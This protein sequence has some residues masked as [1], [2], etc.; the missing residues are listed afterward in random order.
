MR[1]FFILL[2]TL[3]CQAATAA[4]LSVSGSMVSGGSAAG[5]DLSRGATENALFQV[6]EERQGALVGNAGVV[7]D[8]LVGVN[9]GIG[10]AVLGTDGS[11]NLVLPA[12]R[13]DSHIIHFDPVGDQGGNAS[14]GQVTFVNPI[15]AFIVSDR[16]DSFLF[17]ASDGIFGAAGTIH[18]P[19]NRSFGFVD[20]DNGILVDAHTFRVNSA[21]V[22]LTNID[23]VRVITES[24]IPLPPSILALL[25]ALGMLAWRSRSSRDLS[26]Q[27]G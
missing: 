19:G 17:D 25:C 14:G 8:W 9:L 22:T 7:V 12:G 4:V 20:G 10:G 24:T 27:F 21:V 2:M 18:D 11:S 26:A 15:V 5:I 6:F 13:Y 16:S 1:F 3:T 23:Q